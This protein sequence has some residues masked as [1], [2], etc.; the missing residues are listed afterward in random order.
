MGTFNNN[1]IKTVESKKLAIYF[2]TFLTLVISIYIIF[3]LLKDKNSLRSTLLISTFIVINIIV[4][5]KN[6]PYLINKMEFRYI[7]KQIFLISNAF[8]NYL[9]YSFPEKE[10]ILFD[11]FSV[12][13]KNDVSKLFNSYKN[14]E[15][16]YRRNCKDLRN[17]KPEI[18]YYVIYTLLDIAALDNLYSL[19]EEYFIEEVRKLLDINS[20]SFKAIKNAY[21]KKGLKEERKIIEEEARKKTAKEITKSFLPYNAYKILGVSPE[22]TKNQL[23]KVYRELAKKYHP[24]KFHGQSEANIEQ[25]EIKFQEVTEAY[26]IINKYINLN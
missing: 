1:K 15:I 16:T 13:L 19:K 24:D 2:T 26:E 23:K 18:R 6:Y 25:M 7:D 5:L 21:K 12:H 10:K 14:K 8:L 3:L 11:L 22:V 17:S 4:L 20:Q 9:D